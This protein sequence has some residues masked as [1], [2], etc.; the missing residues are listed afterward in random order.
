[1]PVMVNFLHKKERSERQLNDV[2]LQA[3]QSRPSTSDLEAGFSAQYRAGAKLPALH[4]PNRAAAVSPTSPTYSRTPTSE[5]SVSPSTPT[6]TTPV[7]GSSESGRRLL[8]CYECRRKKKGNCVRT[9]AGPC[10]RCLAG[11]DPYGNPLVCEY[12][13]RSFQGQRTDLRRVTD[14]Y[15][16]PGPK[17]SLPTREYYRENGS[18]PRTFSAARGGPRA[19]SNP[20]NGYAHPYTMAPITPINT[21]L[22]AQ[23]Q[24]TLSGGSENTSP[25]PSPQTSRARGK[26]LLFCD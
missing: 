5:Q 3:W 1:M 9:P 21:Q 8:C 2:P 19:V 10:T 24:Y 12:P 14:H 22:A 23:H 17:D 6:S 18:V 20:N 11:R 16:E 4:V 13:T 26:K 25:S 7:T 15:R